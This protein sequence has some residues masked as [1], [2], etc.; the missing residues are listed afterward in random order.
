MCWAGS[1]VYISAGSWSA[2]LAGFS[3]FFVAEEKEE[4]GR[5]GGGLTEGE[6]DVA[7]KPLKKEE[8]LSGR[9]GAEKDDCVTVW[10]GGK[11]WNCTCEPTEAVVVLG[12]K[13]KPSRPTRTVWMA[14]LAAAAAVVVVD[15]ELAGL[16]Y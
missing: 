8:L 6:S 11:K 7:T 12:V 1:W 4:G 13:V 10:L 9:Q 2:V 14:G 16:P 5:E 3:F 15:L